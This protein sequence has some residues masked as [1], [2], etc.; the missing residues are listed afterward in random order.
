MGII[1]RIIVFGGAVNIKT[2]CADYHATTKNV[3]NNDFNKPTIF[4]GVFVGLYIIIKMNKEKGTL[5]TLKKK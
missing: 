2:G 5:S 3:M 4:K 1:S